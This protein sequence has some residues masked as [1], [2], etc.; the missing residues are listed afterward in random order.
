MWVRVLQF[1][2]LR[3]S[4][5]LALV[6]LVAFT[7]GA[8]PRVG[9]I[10]ADGSYKLFCQRRDSTTGSGGSCS[11]CKTEQGC[12]QASTRCSDNERGDGGRHLP[13]GGG[14]AAQR[15]CHPVLN[16][17]A[18]AVKEVGKEQVHRDLS[19]GDLVMMAASPMPA[20]PATIQG[21][22]CGYSASPH[23]D[24]VIALQ[25]LTI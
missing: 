22:R 13:K 24:L 9:C 15:C 12:C 25:R 11:C 3:H 8:A 2:H 10:C 23:V 16:V 6:T 14:V 18:A 5:V 7:L 17:P 19:V 1:R 20:T 21:G 4:K